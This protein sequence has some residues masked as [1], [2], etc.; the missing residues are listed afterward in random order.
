MIHRS[1]ANSDKKADLYDVNF[2]KEFPAIIKLT[3]KLYIINYTY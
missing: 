1:L 3:K 2:M